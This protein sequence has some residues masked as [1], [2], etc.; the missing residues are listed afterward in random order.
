M[1]EFQTVVA[2][3]FGMRHVSGSAETETV[4]ENA[5]PLQHNGSD[6]DAAFEAELQFNRDV[7]KET[8]RLRVRDRAREVID[9]E[10]R[11][12]DPSPPFDAGTLGEVLA[13]PPEPRMRIDGLQPWEA[14]LL[15]VAARKTGK[16]TLQLNYARS[17]LTGEPFLGRFDVTPVE[18]TVAILN[19][20]VSAGMLARWADDHHLDRDR[21]ALVNLRG[22]RNP[23]EHP[24]D[25][26]E[27]AAWL[28]ARQ[29]ES[30][31]VDP[32]GRAYTGQSQNDPGEVGA[33][34]VGLDQFARTEVG[35]RDLLLTAHAGWNGERTRGSSALE[36]WAD[37]IVTLTRD[38]DDESVRFLKALGRDV[39]VDEDRLTYDPTS[40]TLNLSGAGS[41]RKHR[42]DRKVEDLANI[43]TE[44]IRANQGWNTSEVARA[45]KAQSVGHQKGD[46]AKA[47]TL[48]VERGLLR[49]ETGPRGS[50]RYYLSAPT[51][52]YPDVPPA[53][54]VP[55]TP[56]PPIYGGVGGEGR[57]SSTYPE[58]PDRP[59]PPT[60]ESEPRRLGLTGPGRCAECAFHVPTQGHR[61]G[62][63][64]KAAS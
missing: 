37:S 41:R 34:L 2:D 40:R 36:D 18:G 32:F 45:L 14:A 1:N 39:E 53:G 4:A 12:R 51:P 26:A 50:N 49:R 3:A 20:E 55:P 13:R 15:L 38:P 42:N 31:I 43:V 6:P 9:A 25:R 60:T 46:P 35:A 58:P 61:A 28:R 64:T 5:E 19:F 30:L 63:A 8:D 7:H 48:A 33:W 47:L 62:C 52:T 17:L 54:Y 57:S 21:L 11:Q 24:D 22:R 44:V 10:R 23:L 59:E 29:V 16:T 27:L 56:T